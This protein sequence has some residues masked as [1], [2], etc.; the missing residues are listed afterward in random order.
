MPLIS[1][2]IPAG[3]VKHGTESQ[4]AGRWR[5]ANLMR[6]ENGSLRTIGGWRQK[7]DRTATNNTVGVTLGTGQTA[8]GMVSWKDNS[9]TAHIGC[10]TYNK[11]FHINE[12]GTVADITPPSFTA[13]DLDAD[14]NISYGG[15]AYGKGAF[16]IERPS[17]GIIQEATT[18]SL[19]SWGEYLVG[20]SSEDGKLY[21]WILNAANPATLVTQAPDGAK[22][23][24]V[25]EERFVFLLCA[26]AV[27]GDSNLR[28]IVWC[29]QEDLTQWT[30]AATNQA[31]DFELAT[32][33]EIMLGIG[34]RGRTL[35]L[36]TVDAFTAT[37]QAPPTV[38]G[39]EQV[40]R[41]CGA[42]SRHCAV[43]IDEG[44][45]WM[46]Y[47]GFFVYNGSAV[48]DLPCDVHDH[49]FKNLNIGQR[50]KTVCVHNGQHNEVWWFY[51]SNAGTEN[52]S[53]VVYDYKEGHW[54]IGKMDRTSGIDAGIFAHPVYAAPSGK[55]YEHEFSFNTPDYDDYPRAET[56]KIQIGS[57]DQVMDI[58]QVIPDHIS[59]GNIHVSF[60]TR[61]Y[62]NSPESVSK[63]I[64]ASGSPTN[65]RITA[66]EAQLNVRQGD[67]KLN[68]A[69]VQTHLQ[70][71]AGGGLGSGDDVSIFTTV[72][73]GRS[74]GDANNDGLIT[75]SDPSYFGAYPNSHNN[76]DEAV[77]YIT[78]TVIPTLIA[79]LPDT[80]E[81]LTFVGKGQTAALGTIRLDVKAGSK[82]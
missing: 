70:T 41:D 54:N 53:Y 2:D 16:G 47:N 58:T 64:K 60:A 45:F 5:D 80:E 56:G 19:D 40:G 50:S 61:N 68:S 12:S 75:V 6:W 28:R 33:G 38:Y 39:F 23:M 57:G 65:V 26:G 43:S 4:S 18:W 55:I 82:R 49:V 9:G 74:L 31:G 15:F 20:V 62:P 46:G 24:V 71:L 72:I 48:Q 27:A 3:V 42:I 73:N 10:G 29:D 66:R 13:G 77:E 76:D 8:R 79:N 14:Q 25:T 36:T 30:P 37:Y 78:N 52:D 44:A 59:E 34:T 51:P 17:G 35:I 7:E 67:W 69:V 21:Q 32:T 81:F 63:L 22:A 11:L 1:L